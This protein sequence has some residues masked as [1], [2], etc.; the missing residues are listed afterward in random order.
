KI[1]KNPKNQSHLIPKKSH[2][3]LIPKAISFRKRKANT[4][5]C[6]IHNGERFI[7][8]AGCSER[9]F[10]AFIDFRINCETKEVRNS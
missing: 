5:R 3:I 6:V 7:I 8:F 10:Y 9:G 4:K 1:L 2:L